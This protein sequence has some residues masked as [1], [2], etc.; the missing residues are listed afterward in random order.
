MDTIRLHDTGAAVEDVQ[1]RLA[2]AGF[3]DEAEVTGTFDDRTQQALRAF[4]RHFRLPATDMVDDKT[5]ATLVDAS[6]NMGDRTLYLRMP[7]F[8]GADVVQLQRALGALGFANGEHDGIF[9]A[10]TELALRKFQTNMGLP[11]DGIAGAYTFAALRNLSHSWEGK[12]AA[13]LPRTLGF[14]RAA[15]VLEAHALVLFGT[16]EFTRQVASRM[17]NLSL[18][19]NPASRM[20]SADALLVPPDDTMLLVQVTLPEAEAAADAPRVAYDD[21][22]TLSLRLRSAL[23][24]ARDPRAPRPARVIVELPGTVWEDAGAARSAQHFA[25]TLLDALCAAL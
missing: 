1:R 8:H 2:I 23:N 22:D 3:L 15:D 21:E 7:Y 24:A 14:A 18:A 4:A 20:V 17:S 5:W 25:I 16:D 6:F 9:G 11:S 12:E 19:T 10:H 13:H